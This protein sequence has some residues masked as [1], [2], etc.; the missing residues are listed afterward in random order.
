MNV[1]GHAGGL[2]ILETQLL[3]KS[4]IE[5]FLHRIIRVDPKISHDE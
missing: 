3:T 1:R 4:I 5:I 2:P